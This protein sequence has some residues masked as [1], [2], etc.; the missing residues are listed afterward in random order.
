MTPQVLNSLLASPQSRAA[1]FLLLFFASL[2]PCRADEPE[3]PVP[4]I[5]PEAQPT[6]PYRF[7]SPSADGI[8]KFYFDREI[9]HVMGHQAMHWLERSERE[10]QEA[11]R[12]AIDMIELPAQSVIADIGA[13]S[14][15]YSRLL[16]KRFPQGTIIALDIQPEMITALESNLRR[17]KIT[18]VRGHLSQVDSTQLEPASIDAAIMVDAYH[19][20]SHPAEML[21]SLHRALKPKGRLF[22][23]EFRA[24]DSQVPIK[25]LHKMSEQQARRELEANGYTFIENKPDLPWQ[26]FLVFEKSK[27]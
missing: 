25:P 15:Y 21:Q 12:K 23:L 13:G 8:G 18:N 7:Q 2:I 10:T 27:P 26:H 9:A 14:G 5:A 11:C 16:A 20:F 19:E 6:S 4:A 3:R 24:E 17:E 22:L 1:G